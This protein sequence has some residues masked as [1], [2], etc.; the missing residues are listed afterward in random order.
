MLIIF[1]F[2]TTFHP[3]KL[4][5]PHSLFFTFSSPFLLT[6]ISDPAALSRRGLTVMMTVK[7]VAAPL[8]FM[9]NLINLF[10]LKEK[11]KF[12]CN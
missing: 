2:L 9:D 6:T 4:F 3:H 10:V 8:W 12:A 7:T 1:H 5:F 11:L